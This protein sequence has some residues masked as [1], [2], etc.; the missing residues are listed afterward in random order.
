MTNPVHNPQEVS[1][2]ESLPTQV[3][4]SITYIEITQ[5]L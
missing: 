4:S 2:L 5:E 3:A 1:N